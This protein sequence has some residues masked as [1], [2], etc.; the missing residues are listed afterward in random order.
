MVELSSHKTT[1]FLEMMAQYVADSADSSIII[2]SYNLLIC[3]GFL[4][5]TTPQEVVVHTCDLVAQ[6]YRALARQHVE[7]CISNAYCIVEYSAYKV[8]LLLNNTNF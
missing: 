4:L 2:I 3:C 8:L 7:V 5:A 6:L 1:S